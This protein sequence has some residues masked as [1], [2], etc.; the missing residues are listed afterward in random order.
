MKPL[1]QKI[2]LASK[3]PRRRELLRQIGV[4]F[5]LLLL[6]D[7]TPRGPEVSEIVLPNERAEDY[8]ARITLEKA[9]FAQKTMWW[10][11]LPQRPI[12]A[13]DT[14]VVLDGHIL[15]KPAN[16]A[17]AI[18]MMRALSGRTHQVLTHVAILHNEQTLQITQRSDVAFTKLSDEVIRAYCATAEPYDKAGG[19]GIQGQAALFIQDIA[20]SYSGIMGLPLYETGK[21][22][23][24]AGLRIL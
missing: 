1:P 18:E 10:R 12:L 16:E 19:Y 3:S 4:E 13:A 2:Y 14:S 23:E 5:E 9:A 8:V 15:G 17:E 24:Q 7:H 22:L 6:R 20:G 11:K 21:L